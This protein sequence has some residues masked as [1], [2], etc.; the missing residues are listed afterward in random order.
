MEKKVALVTGAGQGI[1]RSIA[2]E[3]AQAGCNVVV[4]DNNYENATLVADEITSQGFVAIPAQGDVRDRGSV[5]DMFA[6]AGKHFSPVEI[7]VNNAGVFPFKPFGETSEAEWDDVFAV[8]MKGIYLCTQEALHAMPN[9]GRIISISSVA[10]NL[11]FIGLVPYCASKGAVNSFTRSLAVELADRE[12]TVN[13]VAP[14]AIDTPGA[15]AVGADEEM[16]AQLLTKIPLRRKGKPEEIASVVRF[17]ASPEARY[18]TGQIVTVDGG[19]TV[20]S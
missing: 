3:L 6:T 5:H 20:Q 12:I 10:A 18:I 17:L 15:G 2:F 1:G 11:G 19:W 9:G 13:A 4:A 16:L 14:G 8:N 7:L